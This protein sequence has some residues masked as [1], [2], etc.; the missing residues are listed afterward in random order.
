MLPVGNNRYFVFVSNLLSFF[1]TSAQICCFYPNFTLILWPWAHKTR[2]LK[3]TAIKKGHFWLCLS[4]KFWC[5]FK[6][7]K[8]LFGI[9]VLI[10][11][12]GFYHWSKSFSG[13]IHRICSSFC[14]EF[15][16][17]LNSIYV[18]ATP[19][20]KPL[21]IVICWESAATIW[22]KLCGS[23]QLLFLISLLFFRQDRFQD[24][25]GISAVES[26]V[27]QEPVSTFW[28]RCLRLKKD[29]K[30]V[31]TSFVMSCKI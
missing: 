28:R 17:K 7:D 15:W 19:I 12:G 25:K 3:I 20:Q 21:C 30:N 9:L 4:F 24:V 22:I 6:S 1:S 18:D 5:G 16:C 8:M 27:D 2:L 11:S 29:K 14:F 26:T 10:F 31:N 23:L 13:Y